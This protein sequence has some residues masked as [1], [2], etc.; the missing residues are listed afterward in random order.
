[1]QHLPIRG[2][3][4]PP[5]S[6]SSDPAAGSD[7]GKPRADEDAGDAAETREEERGEPELGAAPER[8]QEAA[9]IVPTI[10]QRPTTERPTVLVSAAFL[11]RFGRE[12]SLEFLVP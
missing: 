11:A 4:N 3:Q 6:G 1:M 9:A 8:R 10:A 5:R 12:I 7:A 2:Q